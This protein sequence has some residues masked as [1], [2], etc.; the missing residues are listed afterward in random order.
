MTSNFTAPREETSLLALTTA[1][2]WLLCLT[3]GV[4]GLHLAYPRPVAPKPQPP[5]VQAQ[6]V[7]VQITQAARAEALPQPAGIPPPPD[8]ANVAPAPAA[9]PLSAVALPSPAIEFARV[10]KGPTTTVAARYAAP[11]S[12][13]PPVQQLVFGS[14]LGQPAP[15]YPR[16]ATLAHEEGV[17]LVRFSVDQS[18]SVSSATAVDP[19]PFAQLN[20][21]AVRTIRDD[22]RFPPGPARLYEIQ[23]R[24]QLR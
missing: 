10:V 15:E 17:V 18:G 3:V 21:S 14:G 7:N 22:W 20:Q 2:V 12:S 24:F 13:G 1:A 5:P 16:E 11:A 19:S 4:L 6:F 9:P 8:A 23:I